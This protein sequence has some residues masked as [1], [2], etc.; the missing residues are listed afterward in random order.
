MSTD[1]LNDH[2]LSSDLTS[3][4]SSLAAAKANYPGRRPL[5]FYKR[6]PA[7]QED[8]KDVE[9]VVETPVQA[10]E[11]PAVPAFS[12]SPGFFHARRKY[13]SYRQKSQM[14]P[15]EPNLPS[16]PE[17][18]QPS[19]QTT[20][21]DHVPITN[22]EQIISGPTHNNNNVHIAHPRP[23]HPLRM[24]FRGTTTAE[25]PT[26]SNNPEPSG[27]AKQAEVTVEEKPQVRFSRPSFV[28]KIR[29]LRL[30]A[31]DHSIGEQ[32]G[33]QSST[34]E[35]NISVHDDNIPSRRLRFRHRPM[36]MSR[37]SQEQNLLPTEDTTTTTPI[38]VPNEETEVLEGE[39]NS[40]VDTNSNVNPVERTNSLFR[41]NLRR[42]KIIRKPVNPENAKGDNIEE[43]KIEQIVQPEKQEETNVAF[44]L[45]SLKSLNG[46]AMSELMRSPKV[47]EFL[48]MEQSKET[49]TGNNDTSIPEPIDITT[50]EPIVQDLVVPRRRIMM[51]RRPTEDPNIAI[52]NGE[53]HNKGKIIKES[54]LESPAHLTSSSYS[55]ISMN[56]N[57]RHPSNEETVAESSSMNEK[58][59]IANSESNSGDRGRFKVP[60]NFRFAVFQNSHQEEEMSTMEP[61]ERKDHYQ[62]LSSTFPSWVRN[63]SSRIADKTPESS[64]KNYDLVLDKNVRMRPT[65]D[66]DQ[67]EPHLTILTDL[68]N[69]RE[70]NQE[71]SV[72]PLPLVTSTTTTTTTTTTPSPALVFSKPAL[73]N[74][75]N[76]LVP[77]VTRRRILRKRVR[78]P[79][80]ENLHYQ[81]YSGETEGDTMISESQ[82]SE[83]HDTSPVVSNHQGRVR[84]RFKDLQSLKDES[85]A[86]ENGK[87][88]VPTQKMRRPALTSTLL[89]KRTRTRVQSFTT[90]TTEKPSFVFPPFKSDKKKE[91]EEISHPAPV[92]THKSQVEG[93]T[94][95]PVVN[96][97][98]IS[99]FVEKDILSATNNN[100][101]VSNV[102]VDT[103][104]EFHTSKS[105]SE[106]IKSSS[107]STRF[108]VPQ[109]FVFGDNAKHT[110]TVTSNI[111]RVQFPVGSSQTATTTITTNNNNDNSRISSTN[112]AHTQLH[113]NSGSRIS[114]SGQSSHQNNEHKVS[115]GIS[116][117]PAQSVQVDSSAT[118]SV[119]HRRPIQGQTFEQHRPAPN[120]E[121]KMPIQMQNNF[122]VQRPVQAQ[123]VEQQRISS[124]NFEQQRP[125]QNVESK[126]PVHVQHNFEQHVPAQVQ[127]NF[128][129]QGPVQ[130]QNVEHQRI[131][132]ENF[133]LQRPVQ[134]P[135]IGD[136]RRPM[137]N[138]NTMA[139]ENHQTNTRFPINMVFG[140]PSVESRPTAP[141]QTTLLSKQN[142]PLVRPENIVRVNG[143][144]Q[145]THTGFRHHGVPEM[146]KP[147]ILDTQ[148]HRP[149]AESNVRVE[150]TEINFGTQVSF[151]ESQ[152]GH[153]SQQ[154]S[155]GVGS[156]SFLAHTGNNGNQQVMM[157]QSNSGSMAHNNG[158]NL[159]PNHHSSVTISSNSPINDG[160]REQ[161]EQRI[162]EYITTQHGNMGTT[163]TTHA[164]QPQHI[165]GHMN[166]PLVK[167][168][169][170]S[171]VY[172]SE[173]G[174]NTFDNGGK[175]SGH[176]WSPVLE[177]SGVTANQKKEETGMQ[178]LI[179]STFQ[180]PAQPQDAHLTK[181]QLHH[182]TPMVSQGMS[183]AQGSKNQLNSHLS[184]LAPQ[185]QMRPETTTQQHRIPETPSQQYRAPEKST[186][187]QR[188]HEMPSHNQQSYSQSATKRPVDLPVAP[189]R[190]PTM[191]NQP[192][193]ENTE[194][195]HNRHRTH[196]KKQQRL[197]VSLLD[198]PMTPPRQQNRPQWTQNHGPTRSR[199]ENRGQQTRFPTSMLNQKL[200]NGPSFQQ[201]SPMGSWSNTNQQMTAPSS[202]SGV[203]VRGNGNN[204][205]QYG[206]KNP[207]EWKM[208]QYVPYSHPM[209]SASTQ[210]NTVMRPPSPFSRHSGRTSRAMDWSGQ[211]EQSIG[212]MVGADVLD[213]GM[214]DRMV[215][216]VNG[217]E[218]VRIP[219]D[220]NFT[221]NAP[222]AEKGFRPLILYSE[223]DPGPILL[224][225]ESEL[226]GPEHKMEKREHDGSAK[227][228]EIVSPEQIMLLL[229][230]NRIPG[231]MGL[232]VPKAN[233]LENNKVKSANDMM[234]KSTVYHKISG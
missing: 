157:V 167:P 132:F 128:E 65:I 17:L 155:S 41:N 15:T 158:H 217:N 129:R 57:H 102:H 35:S 176:H 230:N 27:E 140:G 161:L 210:V 101:H 71:M 145:D 169:N 94:E 170:I 179:K 89:R 138:T 47:K 222:K 225:K 135:H 26:N 190:F 221:F 127:H 81:T 212:E 11:E 191:Q 92:F 178:N 61:P 53:E 18:Q 48:H 86:E 33:E 112:E 147:V 183:Q 64:G 106:R 7:A 174:H 58:T 173:K 142:M 3:S 38:T 60:S 114:S 45:D 209:G 44:I 99:D 46:P 6:N 34:D 4:G 54:V 141:A 201:G 75:I 220:S 119:D 200:R 13:S 168:T 211:E 20:N 148:E 131:P 14:N 25:P 19:T 16:E 214:L 223:E 130:A 1:S 199:P 67:G 175:M 122:E 24:R 232:G 205:P 195:A 196:P 204:V 123:N 151:Q 51:R 133:E 134:I 219:G 163:F 229:M 152:M 76:K 136:Q 159:R 121:H 59:T 63:P 62:K 50:T 184:Q 224:A 42:R 83:Q 226:D 23:H 143:G 207:H 31:V 180:R 216:D 189:T 69:D 72:D 30:P 213:T 96:L 139:V 227:L 164:P 198:R 37:P 79:A 192:S 234:A 113:H 117:F 233:M 185:Q 22:E 78:K 12:P 160:L 28:P 171:I 52:I 126:R 124:Q 162:H 125:I 77:Q 29:P 218:T 95:S 149:I 103:H 188:P 120:V 110:E 80:A 193:S 55:R 90:T 203:R 231:K 154:F 82:Q 74:G 108:A 116:R 43:S 215:R 144:Q 91:Q 8:P 49:Q 84:F 10:K 68:N 87:D 177:S 56:R 186:Y 115:T 109:R 202:P 97:N 206:P 156:S 70:V 2:F 150:P 39:G 73:P 36:M 208:P 100:N 21:Q 172:Q 118:A 137:H 228:G 111:G 9:P 182:M 66:D 104:K 5:W 194:L 88:T 40:I 98:P 197:P 181:K 146:R 93:Q 32:N 107:S 153:T 165:G 105:N 187:Q 85:D 166:A